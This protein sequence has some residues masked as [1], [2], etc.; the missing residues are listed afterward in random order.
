MDTVEEVLLELLDLELVL[1]LVLLW[2]LEVDVVDKVVE[3][4]LGLVFRDIVV[5][6]LKI[7]SVIPEITVV[8]PD[9]ENAELTGTVT[10]PVKMTSVTP[11]ITVTRPGME[12]I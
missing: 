8:K 12:V 4:E 2:E 11:L 5:G 3:V 6:V 1:L 10:S 7:T 9:N